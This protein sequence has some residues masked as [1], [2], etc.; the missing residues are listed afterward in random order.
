MMKLL[1]IK[2]VS[3]LVFNTIDS[4][5]DCGCNPHWCHP[6]TCNCKCHG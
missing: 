2:K 6:E 5:Y 1:K 4:D 3:L